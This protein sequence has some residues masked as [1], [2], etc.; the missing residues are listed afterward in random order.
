MLRSSALFLLCAFAVFAKRSEGIT[1]EGEKRIFKAGSTSMI[2]RSA[3]NTKSDKERNLVKGGL[4]QGVLVGESEK[5]QGKTGRWIA[6][7]GYTADHYV[8]GGFL[9]DVTGE[10]EYKRDICSLKGKTLECTTGKIAIDPGIQLQ[11]QSTICGKKLG[12]V[13]PELSITDKGPAK[14]GKAL[15]TINNEIDIYIRKKDGVAVQI[16]Y[17]SVPLECN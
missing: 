17:F 6:V 15:K 9:T 11:I 1:T 14:L 7:G 8:F 13:V 2:I 10:Y 5:I 12:Q 16:D 3:Q 4:V